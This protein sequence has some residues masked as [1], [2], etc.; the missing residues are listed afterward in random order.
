MEYR[1]IVA[2]NKNL[3]TDEVTT[4]SKTKP[5]SEIKGIVKV[6]LFNADRSQ[7]TYHAET[8]N[9]INSSAVR[10]LFIEGFYRRL[11]IGGEI[12]SNYS[13]FPFRRIYL[14]DYKGEENVNEKYFKGNVVGWCEKNTTY[15]G[16]ST[17][18]GT[19]NLSESYSEVDSEG[20]ILLHF[21][22]DFPTHA[23]NGTFQTIYWVQGSTIYSLYAIPINILG[24]SNIEA[25]YSSV[26]N[27]GTYNCSDY[28]NVGYY[29]YSIRI[30]SIEYRTFKSFYLSTAKNKDSDHMYFYN[31][32][33]AKIKYG[34]FS[35]TGFSASQQ[36]LFLYNLSISSI[37]IHKFRTDGTWVE[38]I[39]INASNFKDPSGRTP[40]IISFEVIEDN[41]YLTIYYNV[42]GVY[43]NHLIKLN[44]SYGIELDYTI[45]TPS[46]G[47]SSWT[48][49]II[50]KTKAYWYLSDTS[51]ILIFDLSMKMLYSRVSL[52][53]AIPESTRKLFFTKNQN[54]GYCFANGSSKNFYYTFGPA[55]IG[56]QTLLAAPVTKTPTNTMK[57]Q[58]DFILDNVINEIF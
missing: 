9:I 43:I 22:F 20:K 53:S 5:N 6:E 21:V 32:E 38:D 57:I 25:K 33:G 30:N 48:V 55:L 7:K 49:T 45:E 31:A 13:E 46:Y 51:G 23:A 19:I 15:A 10:L 40:G 24:T 47:G 2:F 29:L 26:C 8:E 4:L 14:S 54:Y 34:D 35:I 44:S 28:N 12:N 36:Y 18:Q 58:Y 56:A 16:S 42:N 37:Q 17:T 11:S 39:T 41:L 52:S 27:Y 1:E 50:G 3:I